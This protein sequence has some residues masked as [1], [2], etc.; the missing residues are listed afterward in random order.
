MPGSAITASAPQMG[1]QQPAAQQMAAASFNEGTYEYSE[2]LGTISVQLGGAAAAEVIQNITP[3]GFLR[4]V[5]LYVSS[6][7][8]VIGAGVITPDA[9][10]SVINSMTIES[11]DG[12]P[13]KYPMGGYSYYLEAAFCRPWDGN[14]ASDPAFSNTINPA[15]RMRFFLESRGTMGVVPNT[16]ARA[17]YRFRYTL[18]PT[19]A[20]ATG[21]VTTAPTVTV[22][23]AVETYAQPP[24]T[25]LS[26]APIAQIPDGIAIQRFTSH[27]IDVTSAAN[28]TIKENRVGNLIRSLILVSRDSTGARIDITSDP[29]RLRIDNTQMFVES[30]ARR[31][32]EVNRY[33]SDYKMPA[34][35]RPT[36]VY[37]YPRW[38]RPGD[39]E[40]Q[41][42]LETTEATFLQWEVTGLAAGGTLETITEDLAP[43]AM[44]PAYMN[45]I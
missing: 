37:V 32:F 21:A 44:I 14:P 17:L 28:M 1:G 36:G 25:T 29:I 16:D 18:A 40:G 39:L 2:V 6:A 23:T 27:Q 22:Q 34:S 42:W 45:G 10:W 20:L 3:G 19:V 13:I 33:F 41:W 15:F 38:H 12:T 8:G 31:D 9:P 26:G 4:G 43:A 35:T 11:I 5:S 30:R 24:A 7:G